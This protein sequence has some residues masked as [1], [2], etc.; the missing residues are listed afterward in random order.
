MAFI[1]AAAGDIQ[2]GKS[3]RVIK[4]HYR[5]RL[6]TDESRWQICRRSRHHEKDRRRADRAKLLSIMAEGLVGIPVDLTRFRGC[7][8]TA[9][10]L[11]IPGPPLAFQWHHR[12]RVAITPRFVLEERRIFFLRIPTGEIEKSPWIGD[13]LE[14]EAAVH[15]QGAVV[16]Q[17]PV[18][19]LLPF[20]ANIQFQKFTSDD[21]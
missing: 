10:P 21:P 8:I 12:G 20:L 6:R 5:G 14:K 1:N 3:S 11:L 17:E 15:R 18:S 16:A 13:I 19:L 2:A 9:H 7:G 4:G